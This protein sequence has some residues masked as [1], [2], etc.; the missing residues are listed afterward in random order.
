MLKL[1]DKIAAVRRFYG[2]VT[3]VPI[4]TASRGSPGTWG[5]NLDKRALRTPSK[6]LFEVD[7]EAVALAVAN[8][9]AVQRDIVMLNT[10]HMVSRHTYSG[11][12]CTNY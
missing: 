12:S 9:W 6:K 5:V 7:N 8:E 2:D 1:C 11:L 4:Q 10:M 3:V